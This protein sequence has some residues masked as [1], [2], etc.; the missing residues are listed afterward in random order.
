MQYKRILSEKISSSSS[1]TYIFICSSTSICH[2]LGTAD[3]LPA[4]NGT[5]IV[6]AVYLIQ[7]SASQ[8]CSH[9]AQRSNPFWNM[10]FAKF[11]YHKHM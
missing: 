8:N 5:V 7:Q 4:L 1:C 2:D 11:V 6:N 9:S 3:R 10:Q